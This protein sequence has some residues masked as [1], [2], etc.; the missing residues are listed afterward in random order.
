MILSPL[1]AEVLSSNVSLGAFLNPPNLFLLVTLGYGVPVLVIRELAVRRKLGLQGLLLLGVAYGIY[2]EGI[3]AKTFLLT[4]DVP[5]EQFSG[6]GMLL[7]IGVPWAIL[8]SSWHALFSVLLPILYVYHV[9]PSSIHEP[10]IGKRTSW[11]LLALILATGFVNFLSLSNNGQKGSP[12]QLVVLVAAGSVL[13]VLALRA[14]RPEVTL[15]NEYSG[16]Y[17]WG[18]VLWFAIS[19]AVPI[20]IAGFHAPVLLYL[21]YALLLTALLGFV[22]SR[23]PEVSRDALL[24]FGLGA[25]ICT[26]VGVLVTFLLAFDPQRVLSSVLFLVLFSYLVFSIRSS[27]HPPLAPSEKQQS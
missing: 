14:S 8:I 19:I 20:G 4:R 26:A 24:L 22:F 2:N 17:V 13:S 23:R 3:I 25:Q 15:Q 10:W 11:V 9:F 1:L 6:Y 27:A 18:G 5:L 12:L 21:A 16:K 7:G